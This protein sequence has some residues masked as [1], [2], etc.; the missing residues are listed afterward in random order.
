MAEHGLGYW[1]GA[2]LHGQI[3]GDLGLYRDRGLGRFQS[4]ETC[5]HFR[6]Q[7]VC[8]RLIYE[9]A[10][11]GFH[12]MGLERLVM[13]ADEAYHAAKIYEAVGFVPVCKEYSAYWWNRN[14]R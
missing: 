14:K 5:P 10:Q 12:H 9:A 1:F 6:R 11:F 13:V 7:G 8:G 3:V 2:F 4:V